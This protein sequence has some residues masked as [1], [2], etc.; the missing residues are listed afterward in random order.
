MKLVSTTVECNSYAIISGVS[1]NLVANIPQEVAEYSPLIC[2]FPKDESEYAPVKLPDK[3]NAS[4][5]VNF[6]A[7]CMGEDSRWKLTKVQV[8]GNRLHLYFLDLHSAHQKEDGAVVYSAEGIY[9]E[10]PTALYVCAERKGSS[11]PDQYIIKY[12]GTESKIGLI[13]NIE[14]LRDEEYYTEAGISFRDGKYYL[15][16]E[17]YA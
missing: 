12:F 9:I 8:L 4:L 13:A 11:A 15:K 2:R 6:K 14:E 3:T 1:A 5:A 17:Y 16:S 10:S 7:A